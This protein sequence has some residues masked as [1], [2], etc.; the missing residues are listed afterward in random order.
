MPPP[1]LHPHRAAAYP[2]LPPRQQP[3]GTHTAANSS[4]LTDGSAATLIMSDTK[5]KELGYKPKSYLREWTFVSVV[6]PRTSI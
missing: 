3:H 5:A 4:F 1:S 2:P 6:R